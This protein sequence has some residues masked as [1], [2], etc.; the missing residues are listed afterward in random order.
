MLNSFNRASAEG[1][2]CARAAVQLTAE[3]IILTQG[4]LAT[5]LTHSAMLTRT[6]TTLALS[7]HEASCRH[8]RGDP[9]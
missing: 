5:S 3:E 1:E 4:K 9:H 8:E 7:P 6:L 2:A